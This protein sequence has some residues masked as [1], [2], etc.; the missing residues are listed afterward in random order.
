[1]NVENV[2]LHLCKTDD[3]CIEFFKYFPKNL[4]EI[5]IGIWNVLRALLQMIS[6]TIWTLFKQQQSVTSWETADK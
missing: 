5:T 1:M 6:G 4:K 3:K 2:N